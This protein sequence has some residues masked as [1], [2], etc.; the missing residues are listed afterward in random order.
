MTTVS[1][2]IADGVATIAMNRPERLN[3]LNEA[4]IGD[5]H[6]GLRQTLTDPAIGAV[7][8]T[9]AGDRAFCVGEDLQDTDD[10][11]EPAARDLVERLQDLTRLILFGT[12]PVIAAING[13]AVGGGFELAM[14][15]DLSIW[16]ANAGAFLPEIGLG[17]GVSGA[18]TWLLP[19]L[20]GW[21]RANALFLLG[22]KQSAE[23]LLDIG[24][25]HRVVPADQLM[26][27]ARRHAL[28]LATLPTASV[29]G[30]K[31]SR[32]AAD[33][34][35]IEA[36]LRA[37]ADNLVGRLCDPATRQRIKA[38]IASRH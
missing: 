1:I 25:A 12:K 14:N 11:T 33:R 30:F 8:L 26:I 6:H 7:I 2:E 31:R 5:L 21:Q 4:M 24:L 10:L 29:A 38:F 19:R 18:S 9:G 35:Q 28:H 17:L 16:S 36:A 3:A 23:A 13:W 32:V 22:E 34:E 27:E 20:V 37:E 15:C